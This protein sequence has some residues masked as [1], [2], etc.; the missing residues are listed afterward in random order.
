MIEGLIMVLLVSQ[1]LFAKT[2]GGTNTDYAQ[3]II[4]ATDGGL[5]IAGNTASFGAGSHDF[6]VLKLNS[7]GSLAWAR[8]FGGTSSEFPF[9]IT[10]ATDGG[11]VIAGETKSFGAGNADCLVIKI[12]NNGTLQWA[13][14]FGGANDDRI[15]SITRTAD[16]GYVAT[17]TT[18]S[19][20]DNF[21]D[22]L[23]LRIASDGSLTWARTFGGTGGETVYSI[24]QT[25][26][27]G[28]AVA[29]ATF[30]FGA[31]GVDDFVL[32]LNS[33]GSLAWARTFGG[34]GYDYTQ[35]L[36]QTT[37][38]SYMVAGATQTFGVGSQD[39]FVL[40]LA[41]NGTLSWAETFGRTDD[42]EEAAPY[43]I[44][45]ADGGYVILGNTWSSGYPD[46]LVLKLAVE[47]SYPGCVQGCSPV[48][49]TPSISTSSPSLTATT[50][51]PTIM[52]P[53]PTVGTP[54]PVI[55]DVCEPAMGIGETSSTQGGIACSMFQG[56][57]MFNSSEAMAINIY[58]TDGRLVYSGQLEKGQNRVILE[59]GVY[60][61][62]AGVYKGTVV[63]R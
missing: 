22:I 28:Y 17:G 18:K 55:T 36:T 19:F 46:F 21:G 60:L 57:V 29:S 41:S 26:D 49:T 39:L 42:F 48:M 35:S 2:Y 63:V 27:G 30:S 56:G 10:Q 33:D 4:Q 58:S 53:S 38:G 3:S 24:I 11:Y 20:G 51:T 62:K 37:D 32:K 59:T 47:G 15:Q 9:S 54:N 23:V 5:L 52:N 34:T 45:T 40:K 14:T 7:D 13:R 43:I 61:W 16:G 1:S 50:C 31:G 44:R 12:T 6:L 25:A 8:T